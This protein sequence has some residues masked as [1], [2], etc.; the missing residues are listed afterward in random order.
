MFLSAMVL[1]LALQGAPQE[2]PRTNRV[3]APGQ[4]SGYVTL[5]CRV[6]EQRRPTDCEIVEERPIS[7]GLAAAA[8][9][10]APRRT[11]G[12]GVLVGERIVFTLHFGQSR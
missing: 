9:E 7:R 3:D 8:L 5:L 11:V 1:A 6:S 4:V 10:A 2:R 12:R